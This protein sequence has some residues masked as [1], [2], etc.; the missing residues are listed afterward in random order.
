MSYI[1]TK[2]KTKTELAQYL[3]ACAFSPAISTFQEY[4]KRGKFVTWPGIGNLNFQKLLRNQEATPLGH[5]DQERRNMQST[6]EKPDY[7]DLFPTKIMTIQIN[8]I[9]SFTNYTK[10][11]VIQT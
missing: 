2:D 6:K 5:L 8:V 9:I 11:K 3:H 1:V 4:I 10:D 7:E